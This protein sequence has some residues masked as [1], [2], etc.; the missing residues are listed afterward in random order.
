MPGNFTVV[1][2]APAAPGDPIAATQAVGKALDLHQS[3]KSERHTELAAL[4]ALQ[5]QPEPVE[6]PAGDQCLP[7]AGAVEE[8]R[9]V[10]RRGDRRGHGP[11]AAKVRRD[12][13]DDRRRA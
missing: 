4:D 3:V 10:V 13:R 12:R 2:T 8:A 9:V 7:V 5:L 1:A 6:G 11:A